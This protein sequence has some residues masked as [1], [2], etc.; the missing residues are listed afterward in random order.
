MSFCVNVKKGCN[1]RHTK[2]GFLATKVCFLATKV[3]FL[4]TKVGFLATKVGFLATKVCFLATKVGFFTRFSRNVLG[5][6]GLLKKATLFQYTL[7]LSPF[8]SG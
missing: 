3:C 7:F 1:F 6:E 2:V 4:A 8:P 5:G